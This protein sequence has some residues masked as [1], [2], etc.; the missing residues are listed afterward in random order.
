MATNTR[1]YKDF[2]ISFIKHPITKDIA[3]KYDDED[4]KA[5]IR[6]LLLTSNYE[7][8]FHSEIGSRLKALLFEPITPVLY[9]VIKR[10]VLNVVESFEPR[11]TILDAITTYLPDE[12][13]I[14]INV[15]FRINGTSM[16]SNTNVT[17]EKTR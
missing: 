12:N 16:I 4:I 15:I 9:S 6:N 14:T 1:T 8:P 11:A 3:M 17:L 10:E 7:R 13:A 2:D 5:S